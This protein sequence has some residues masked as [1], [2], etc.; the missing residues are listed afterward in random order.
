MIRKNKAV[1]EEG[2]VQLV[3][4]L[5]KEKCY[6]SSTYICLFLITIVAAIVTIQD[7]IILHTYLLSGICNEICSGSSNL[8]KLNMKNTCLF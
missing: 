8:V 6:C 1:L 3:T 5:L 2:K 4:L 7:D